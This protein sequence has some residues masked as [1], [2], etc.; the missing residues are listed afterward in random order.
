MEL[1]R[2]RSPGRE[3]AH[4]HELLG[5]RA[6]SLRHPPRAQVAPG[7]A[8]ERPEVEPGVLVEPVVLDGEHRVDQDARRLREA[9][10]PVILAG[11]VGRARQ[12]LGRERERAHVTVVVRDPRDPVVRH[13]QTN[14]TAGRAVPV[15]EDDVPGSARAPELSRRGR[16]RA[17]L[18]VAE[19][20]ERRGQTDALH[21]HARSQGLAR[22]VHERAPPRIGVLEPRELDGGEGDHGHR[23]ARDR[24]GEDAPQ[25]RHG[26]WPPGRARPVSLKAPSRTLSSPV[27]KLY[28]GIAGSFQRATKY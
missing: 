4:L 18:R 23:R 14:A 11:A 21:V 25:P 10:R 28:S 5:D 13:L 7:R 1:S 15:A 12:D 22:R 8:Q 17:R 16:R 2:E 20:P 24:D 27:I 26:R 6:P 9:H 19:A 3:Q